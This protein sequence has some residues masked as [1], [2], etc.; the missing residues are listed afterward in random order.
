MKMS[1]KAFFKNP[2]HSFG[3]KKVRVINASPSPKY[4][5]SL[6]HDWEDNKGITATRCARC[7]KQ[8][9]EDDKDGGHVLKVPGL[10][11]DYYVVPLCKKCN[12]ANVKEPYEVDKELLVRLLSIKWKKQIENQ[13]E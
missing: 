7:G 2:F 4:S 5:G 12:N 1:M 11:F 8:L 10:P 6:I 9:S 13:Y 3:P